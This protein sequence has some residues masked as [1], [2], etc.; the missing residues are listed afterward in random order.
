MVA[1]NIDVAGPDGVRYEAM[2]SPPTRPITFP[3][4]V[5]PLQV[6]D[7]TVDFVIPFFANS[8]FARS[9]YSDSG[10]ITLSVT[11]RYQACDDEQC[12]L[13]RTHTIDL[14]VPVDFGVVPAFE[15]M[16]GRDADV[17]DMDSMAHMTRLFERKAAEQHR[18]SSS[19]P[20][21]R[22]SG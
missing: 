4:L 12:F 5:Q 9:L 11:V 20:T 17:I 19:T 6:W 8:E 10:S 22:R 16:K 3:G 7:G 21:D 1:T 18:D 13:P 15:A 14:D 2:E